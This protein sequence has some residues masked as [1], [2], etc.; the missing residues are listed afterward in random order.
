VGVS[1]RGAIVGFRLE[2][3]G[4]MVG[5]FTMNNGLGDG[6]I[7]D[8]RHPQTNIEI[9]NT[10]EIDSFILSIIAATFQLSILPFDRLSIFH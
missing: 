1:G 8:E 3:G 9:T 5:E 4:V 2:P 10:M 7:L 6:L